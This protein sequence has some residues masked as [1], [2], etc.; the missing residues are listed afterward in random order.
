MFNSFVKKI[1]IININYIFI[2]FYNDW[3]KIIFKWYIIFF[4]GLRVLELEID[5]FGLFVK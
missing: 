3:W 1:I 4:E 5:G 2:D